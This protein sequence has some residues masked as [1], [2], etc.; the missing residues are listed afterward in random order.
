[1]GAI[2]FPSKTK[3]R[4]TPLNDDYDKIEIDLADEGGEST[5]FYVL[6]K[7]LLRLP[8]PEKVTGLY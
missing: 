2:K 8:K 3:A 5:E 6:G 4:L 7:V 1:M